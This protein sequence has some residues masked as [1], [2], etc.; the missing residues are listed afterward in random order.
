MIRTS[1][2]QTL[3]WAAVAGAIAVSAGAAQGQSGVPLL[4]VYIDQPYFYDVLAE[5]VREEGETAYA[6][7]VV[8]EGKEVGRSEVVYDCASGDYEETE[9]DAWTG[10]AKDFL[11]AALLSFAQRYC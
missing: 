8:L 7:D 9:I 11:P 10:G 5:G 3:R 4:R 6:L 1:G 2:K